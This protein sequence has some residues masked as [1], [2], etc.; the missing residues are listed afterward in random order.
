MNMIESPNTTINPKK[1]SY[2]MTFFPKKIGSISEVKKAPVDKHAKVIE[3]LETLMALKKVNQ[4]KAM[5]N[6]ATKNLS[7][8]LLGILIEI[9][10]TLMKTKI[11]K[12]AN[13]ILNQTSGKAS[14]VISLP[15]IAVNPQMNTIR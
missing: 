7:R 3:T 2:Q 1:I 6:P 11:K 15:K 9:F 4:C 14:S 12:T 5:T 13:S 10:F 8:I